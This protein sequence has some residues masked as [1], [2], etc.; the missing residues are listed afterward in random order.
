MFSGFKTLQRLGHPYWSRISAQIS[1]KGSVQ[2]KRR[3][4]HRQPTRR[5]GWSDSELHSQW[6]G[7]PI[8]YFTDKG[9]VRNCMISNAVDALWVDRPCRLLEIFQDK[10]RSYACMSRPVWPR[11]FSVSSALAFSLANLKKKKK[12]WRYQETWHQINS[13]SLSLSRSLARY[14][15]WIQVI[16]L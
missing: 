2:H 4:N 16:L 6:K 7:K 5:T 3:R 13:L 14:F 15:D 8:I 9:N 11:P 12:D 1:L 10:F